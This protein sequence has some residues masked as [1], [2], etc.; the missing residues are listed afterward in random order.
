MLTLK[1]VNGETVEIEKDEESA[2]RNR[3]I[4]EAVFEGQAVIGGFFTDE[5]PNI[6][7]IAVTD[8]REAS[9]NDYTD[10]PEYKAITGARWTFAEND[11][12]RYVQKLMNKHG[13]STVI[14]ILENGIY[15]G[16]TELI[17]NATSMKVLCKHWQ[18][19]EA[20]LDELQDGIGIDGFWSGIFKGGVSLPKLAVCAVEE[21]IRDVVVHQLGLE[22]L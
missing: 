15:S 9:L 6:N 1:L 3:D 12:E 11:F 5:E 4:L 21:T 7:D 18:E 13:I 22:D 2:I 10:N 14:G 17:Y 20:K 19:I 16:Y 8:A